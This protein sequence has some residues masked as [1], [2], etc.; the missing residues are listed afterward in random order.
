MSGRGIRVRSPA[1]AGLFY[2]RDRDRLLKQLEEAFLKGPGYVPKASSFTGGVLGAVVPHAGYM[3]SGYVAAYAYAELAKGGK[4]ETVILIGPNHHAYGM[5]VA[6]SEADAW[7]TPLGRVEVD[8]ESAKRVAEWSEVATFDES[9]HA[10]EHSLEVQ[11]PFL[12]YIF[13]SDFKIVPITMYLQELLVA[14]RLGHAIARL[15]KEL[16]VKAYLIASSDFTHYEEA[17]RAAE[18]DSAAIEA[19]LKLDDRGFYN[20]IIERDVTACGYGPIM[21]LIAA[22]RDLAPVKAQL[23]KYANSG[24][25]TGD[26]SEVVGYASICFY[27]EA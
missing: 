2:E 26:Y 24:D 10:Y 13:G 8:K 25:V 15:I 19:I 14:R 6:I 20:V 12:Q 17:R 21:A 11:L 16:G 23:L 9:A 3:Y 1:V 4:P 5:P 22:A 27:R 7:E 18:K